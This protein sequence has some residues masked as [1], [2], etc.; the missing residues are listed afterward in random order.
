MITY[1]AC[2]ACKHSYKQGMI[3][4]LYE[5]L[6]A[7]Q[8]VYVIMYVYVLT[9]TTTTTTTILRPFVRDYPSESVPEG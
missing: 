3:P 4:C 1:T 7:L 8:A 2:N 5:C 6:H 9:T